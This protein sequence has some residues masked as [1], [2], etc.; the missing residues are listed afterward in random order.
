MQVSSVNSFYRKSKYG[1]DCQKQT[2][3]TQPSFKSSLLHSTKVF[4]DKTAAK[5]V[6]AS[7][8]IAAIVLSALAGLGVG[9]LVS[10]VVPKMPYENAIQTNS[11][12][13]SF[14]KVNTLVN[15]HQG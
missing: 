3:T 10:Q 7:T 15:A 12:G 6:P 13:D 9:N 14:H 5:E 2:K 1:S 8:K 4:I 11:Q